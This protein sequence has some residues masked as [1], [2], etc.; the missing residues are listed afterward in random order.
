MSEA[1]ESL[2]PTFQD[3]RGRAETAVPSTWII[4]GDADR[5]QR[6]SP[7]DTRNGKRR[8]P[9]DL[10]KAYRIAVRN[11][12]CAADDA[13][14]VRELLGCTRRWAETLTKPA[15][16][17]A[18]AARDA[19]IARL[20]AAGLSTRQIAEETGV[21]HR[22]AQRIAA[23][24]KANC[25]V[26]ARGSHPTEPAVIYSPAGEPKSRFASTVSP[27]AAHSHVDSPAFVAWNDLFDR[28]DSLNEGTDVDAL[29][30]ERFPKLE[31]RL[32]LALEQA[33]ETLSTILQTLKVSNAA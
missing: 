33:V 6:P 27:F 32:V 12:L 22:T 8:E 18:K 19:G 25:S 4:A 9:G 20:A 3:I 11:G 17:E 14:A 15:R 26:L 5:R 28:L 23:A 24:P 21:P 30:A 31:P 13:E 16:E 10:R 7:P 2:R 29:F 1:H